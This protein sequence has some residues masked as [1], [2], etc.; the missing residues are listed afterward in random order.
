MAAPERHFAL[1]QRIRRLEFDNWDATVG[2][3][4]PCQ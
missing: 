2:D 4:G 3:T 1:E